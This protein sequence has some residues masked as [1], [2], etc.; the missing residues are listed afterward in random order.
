MALLLLALGLVLGAGRRTREGGGGA[1]RGY[2]GASVAAPA[3]AGSPFFHDSNRHSS[4][5]HRELRTA[6]RRGSGALPD[7]GE[8][9]WTAHGIST[10]EHRYP[11]EF[12]VG[13][14]PRRGPRVLRRPVRVDSTPTPAA[15]GSASRPTRCTSSTSPIRRSLEHIVT[16]RR[17]ARSSSRDSASAWDREPATAPGRR[18][19]LGGAGGPDSSVFALD[20]AGTPVLARPERPRA[21]AAGEGARRG[22]TR[23]RSPAAVGRERAFQT[24]SATP[25]GRFRSGES[26]GLAATGPADTLP[27]VSTRSVRWSMALDP[28]PATR[29]SDGYYRPRGQPPTR[30][31]SGSPTLRTR[32]AGPGSRSA[33][34]AA[35][36]LT[37][38]RPSRSIRSSSGCRVFGGYGYDSESPGSID[39]QCD[40]V[41]WTFEPGGRW[42]YTSHS[43]RSGSRCARAGSLVLDRVDHRLVAFDGS[44]SPPGSDWTIG[45]GA[46]Q[47]WERGH[48]RSAPVRLP[49]DGVTRRPPGT[50]SGT[51][52]SCSAAGSSPST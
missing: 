2:V 23:R 1:G 24:R 17:A 42:E 25:C 18:G 15:S 43:M 16:D 33:G 32:P 48:T 6:G 31:D 37:V 50:R 30:A 12:L 35:P 20:L 29:R 19:R 38:S 47:D 21:D 49:A 10:R 5:L 45:L 40:L 28:G 41:E 11:F 7:A 51:A 46:S 39:P 14:R 44:E 9:T 36:I 52:G 26:G 13:V 3:G 34:T 27:D 8:R 4:D 22:W